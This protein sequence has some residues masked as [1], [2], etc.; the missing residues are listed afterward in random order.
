MASEAILTY[1]TTSTFPPNTSLPNAALTTSD[2]STLLSSLRASQTAAYASLREHTSTTTPALKSWVAQARELQTSIANARKEAAAIVAEAEAVQVLRAETE[3][4]G[5]KVA[6]LE[7][8]VGFTSSLTENLEVVRGVW[9][10]L[11][12]GR[13]SLESGEVEGTLLSLQTAEQGIGGL[14]A[15]GGEKGVGGCD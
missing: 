5:R 4:K 10:L 11:Q 14:E 2:I 13:L 3:E 9:A 6:L 1:L 12:E 7:R 15:G 8:E